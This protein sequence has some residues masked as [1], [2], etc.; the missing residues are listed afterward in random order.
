MHVHVC[1]TECVCVRFFSLVPTW[2]V[3]MSGGGSAVTRDMVAANP[4][5]A[6]ART[7][8]EASCSAAKNERKKERK[9][10]VKKERQ[11]K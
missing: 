7:A 10:D 4:R 11:R 6:A 5:T 3:L 8:A 2:N 9:K 1:A